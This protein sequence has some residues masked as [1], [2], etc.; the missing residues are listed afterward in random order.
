M[1]PTWPGPVPSAALQNFSVFRAR[2]EGGGDLPCDPT[3]ALRLLA[4]AAAEEELRLRHAEDAWTYRLGHAGDSASASWAS[5]LRRIEGVLVSSRSIDRDTLLNLAAEHPG[6]GALVAEFRSLLRESDPELFFQG[7]LGLAQRSLHG[8]R[9]PTFSREL[10]RLAQTHPSTR[11]QAERHLALMN[12]GGGAMA[13]MEFQAPR[14]LRELAS[15]LSLASFGTA[16]FAARFASLAVL[17]RS[18]R[19]GWGALLVSEGAALAVE[20]PTLTFSRRLGTQIFLGGPGTFSSEGLA[21]ELL[22]GYTSFGLLRAFGNGLQLG[23]PALRRVAGLNQPSG[24]FSPFGRFTFETLRLGGEIT[25][26]RLGHSLNVALGFEP[27]PPVGSQPWLQSLLTVGHMRLANRLLHSLGFQPLEGALEAQRRALLLGRPRSDSDT[28]GT[29]RGL[30]LMPEFAL[31]GPRFRPRARDP[32]LEHVLFMS[33]DGDGTGRGSRPDAT[34]P[35]R[36]V[37]IELLQQNLTEYTDRAETRDTV[38][39]KAAK[40][41]QDLLARLNERPDLAHDEAFTR[42]LQEVQLE[43]QAA[44]EHGSA[45]RRSV[46]TL[47]VLFRSSASAENG[48]LKPEVA[49]QKSAQ[50]EADE[51]QRSAFGNALSKVQEVLQKAR[52]SGWSED[53]YGQLDRARTALN[54]FY[55]KTVYN[56]PGL[57]RLLRRAPSP[58]EILQRRQGAVLGLA[59]ATEPH[60]PESPVTQRLRGLAPESIRHQDIELE[61]LHEAVLLGARRNWKPH[62]LQESLGRITEVYRVSEETRAAMVLA[63]QAVNLLAQQGSRGPDL[64]ELLNTMPESLAFHERFLAIQALRDPQGDLRVG[65]E[66]LGVNPAA[67][68]YFSSGLLVMLRSG[69]DGARLIELLHGA[70]EARVPGYHPSIPV[71]LFGAAYGRKAIPEALLPAGAQ[72]EAFLIRAFPPPPES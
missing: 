18:S 54:G 34:P 26:L 16:I 72:T 25:A 57:N 3:T 65:L 51:N 53:L 61:L 48:A 15:P 1:R 20:V 63:G 2:R 56:I 68:D 42:S 41:L 8:D 10:F 43:L 7:V 59:L 36:Q 4:V 66:Q 52:D 62:E 31:A 64:I 69:G 60:F 14:L 40:R 45:L 9:A 50:I 46:E 5:Y 44:Q 22:A 30:D 24:A 28:S 35:R 17:A 37:V 11:D 47:K 29:Q 39:G 70:R 71:S 6:G 23:A 19:L 13:Q 33:M 12:G 32:K 58:E 21:N 67:P 49:E 38:L 27:T 55:G